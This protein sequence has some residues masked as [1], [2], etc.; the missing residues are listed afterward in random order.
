MTM[1]NGAFLYEDDQVRASLS[2]D[3]AVVDLELKAAFE[4]TRSFKGAAEMAV[5][6]KGVI[7]SAPFLVSR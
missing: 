6:L 1:E 2:G 5:I 7:I 4:G 3:G